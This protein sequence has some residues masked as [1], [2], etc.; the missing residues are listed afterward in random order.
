MIIGHSACYRRGATCRIEA[1]VAAR[2]NDHGE[3]RHC[4]SIDIGHLEDA[5]SPVVA[6]ST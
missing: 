3:V 4:R 6:R 5:L 2:H 1:P